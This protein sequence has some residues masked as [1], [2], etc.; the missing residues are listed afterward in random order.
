LPICPT[1]ALFCAKLCV[2]QKERGVTVEDIKT[3]EEELSLDN[4]DGWITWILS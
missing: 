4:Y 2:T 3:L 1:A